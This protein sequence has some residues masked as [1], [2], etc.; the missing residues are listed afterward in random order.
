MNIV[1]LDAQTVGD[2]NMLQP[3]AVLGNL[4]CYDATK[5]DERLAH[6]AHAEVLITNKVII[7]KPLIDNLPNL[8][9][10]CI[11]ATGMNC[12]DVEYA[13]SKG[14]VVKNVAG[15]STH[16][17]AQHTFAMLL[18]LMHGISGYDSY[19]KSGAYCECPHF[20]NIQTHY[21]QLEGKTYGIIGL[22]EI[23][24]QVA[25]V[26]TAFGAKVIYHSVSGKN[27]GQAY[28]HVSLSELLAQSD[29]VS[30]HAPLNEQTKNLLAKNELAQ[31]KP[32]AFLVNVGRGGIVNEADLAFA[33]DNH[34]IAG[35][36]TD[37]FE[38]EPM[39]ADSPFM[40][41]KHPER[42]LFTPHVAWTSDEALATLIKKIAENIQLFVETG[43]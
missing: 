11:S 7:D 30:I 36:V 33:I 6:C 26:A 43:R 42:M 2:A 18:S 19:V 34:I 10:V 1:F 23:G 32:T 15:Y 39:R 24:R 29:I 14:I 4:I 13:R 22:G 37:V 8:K 5:P 40:H 25:A 12:V 21:Y 3:I 35:A 20:T 28:P 17:V 41:L 27:L 31:M 16:S 9:L 38:A